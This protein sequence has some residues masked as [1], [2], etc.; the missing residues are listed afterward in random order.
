M[1]SS[2]H[3]AA[4]A[5]KI[6]QLAKEL[7]EST[8]GAVSF[9]NSMS[10]AT[11]LGDGLAQCDSDALGAAC[12]VP[13]LARLQRT[14]FADAM[15]CHQPV[16][17]R[18]DTV[19][20]LLRNIV[21]LDENDPVQRI[22]PPPSS[23]PERQRSW[24]HSGASIE[25]GGHGPEYGNWFLATACSPEAQVT[26]SFLSVPGARATNN[27][28]PAP[29]LQEVEVMYEDGST[30]LK[31]RDL[32]RPAPPPSPKGWRH[33]IYCIGSHRPASHPDDLLLLCCGR[34]AS[35]V[36]HGCSDRRAPESL[37]ITV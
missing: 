13:I 26:R 10:L 17:A 23:A 6:E 8:G 27:T 36:R 25:A 24:L 12:L 22:V 9:Q 5:A 31:N 16:R 32:L 21:S 29:S 4:D 1:S 18:L 11:T 37:A 30:E 7:A 28:S 19:D 3:A 2:N 20:E 33:R 34:L 14:L 35:R 15:A